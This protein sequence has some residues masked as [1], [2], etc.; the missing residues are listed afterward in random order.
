MIELPVEGAGHAL[1]SSATA[2]PLPLSMMQGIAKSQPFILAVGGLV[3]PIS[4][5]RLRDFQVSLAED[6]LAL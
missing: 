6:A 1:G 3:R 5:F 2:P 4:A